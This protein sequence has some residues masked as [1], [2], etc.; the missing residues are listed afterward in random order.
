MNQFSSKEQAHYYEK[1]VSGISQNMEEFENK[2]KDIMSE[3][4]F[5]LFKKLIQEPLKPKS[6]ANL[7]IKYKL[8]NENFI[9]PEDEPGA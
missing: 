8:L 4:D 7:L 5:I 1:S 3:E 9:A 6:L 2:V